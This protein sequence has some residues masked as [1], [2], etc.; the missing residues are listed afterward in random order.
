M[1]AE[2][3]SHLPCK[4]WRGSCQGGARAAADHTGTSALTRGGPEKGSYPGRGGRA[5]RRVGS[6]PQEQLP[7]HSGGPGGFSRRCEQGQA[8]S[9]VLAS[10]PLAPR[11]A[12]A[13]TVPCPF[14]PSTGK[15]KGS[16]SLLQHEG[17][18][19][20]GLM[21]RSEPSLAQRCTTNRKLRV[22]IYF[23]GEKSLGS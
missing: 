21:M 5:G 10:L 6:W 13:S 20:T 8:R 2:L 7:E 14:L 23:S 1:L 12:Q 11:E 3:A 9:P 18:F 4:C 22:C 19:G 17:F 16:Q 15:R